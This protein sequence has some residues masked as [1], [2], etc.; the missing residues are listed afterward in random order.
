MPNIG[1]PPLLTILLCTQ[2]N[3]QLPKL[4][5][6]LALIEQALVIMTFHANSVHGNRHINIM[7]EKLSMRKHRVNREIPRFAYISTEREVSFRPIVTDIYML[8]LYIDATYGD[9]VAYERNTCS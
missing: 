3:I 1:P 9:E 6:E 4:N 5:I 2:R 7:L 8:Q